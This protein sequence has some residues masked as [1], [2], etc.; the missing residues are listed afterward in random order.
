MNF[1]SKIFNKFKKLQLP[2]EV[3]KKKADFIIKNNFN[4]N[5][6]KKNV[7]KVLKEIL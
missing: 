7:K 2:I 5:S 1:N 4:N 6:T 3:K